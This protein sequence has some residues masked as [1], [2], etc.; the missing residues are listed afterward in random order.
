MAWNTKRD[1][2]Y[3]RPSDQSPHTPT[4]NTPTPVSTHRI[5]IPGTKFIAHVNG[6]ERAETLVKQLAKT[7]I[8]SRQ[9]GSRKVKCQPVIT[10]LTISKELSNVA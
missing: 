8:P 10:E 6:I 7:N 5:T 9:V 4:L 2:Y 1:G 3:T